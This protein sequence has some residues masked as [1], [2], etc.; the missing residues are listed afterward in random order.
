MTRG[1]LAALVLAALP[2]GQ[3]T[4]AAE[5]TPYGKGMTEANTQRLV[6]DDIR[7]TAGWD[8]GSPEETTLSIS[9]RHARRALLF[10][11][12]VDHTQ[13][14]KN[15]PVGWPRT[16]LNLAKAKRTDWSGYDFFEC[17]IYA[18]A[19]RP[20]LPKTPISVG[21]YHSG[22][23]R[24][25]HFP[26]TEVRKDAWAKV[27]IPVARLLDPKDVQRVQFNI[28]E[29]DYK[30]GDRADFYIGDVALA[31]FAE[32]AVA[33]LT[34]Q[35]GIIY[36]NARTFRASYKLVGHQ[37]L[38]GTKVELVLGLEGRPP[39]ARAA[40]GAARDGEIALPIAAP[41]EPGSYRATLGLRDAHG[42]LIDRKDA[43]VRVIRGPF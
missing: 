7:D 9:D 25:S 30:H 17:W 42:K 18:E 35:R 11:N 10:A 26:L 4:A 34:P 43:P 29:S 41:L 38:E 22:Q 6:L 33:E 28:S 32:P 5:E 16:G 20:S 31:R 13:G 3:G 14:E 40:A 12:V 24:S 23:K 19:S 27:V 2:A 36:S 37:G 8:N 39:A 1:L 15:Y 21:F